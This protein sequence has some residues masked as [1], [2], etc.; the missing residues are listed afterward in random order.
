MVNISH[1]NDQIGGNSHINL[2]NRLPVLFN[3]WANNW[4]CPT[5]CFISV[6]DIF[7]HVMKPTSTSNNAEPNLSKLISPYKIELIHFLISAWE[8]EY[9]LHSQILGWISIHTDIPVLYF[10]ADNHSDVHR[11][12]PA[13]YVWHS[14]VV[15]IDVIWDLCSFSY[16]CFLYHKQ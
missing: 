2:A 16:S 6:K 11:Q 12:I 5:N 3:A 15:L 1:N 7:K 9:T 10:Y 14:W 8:T 4:S 13:N